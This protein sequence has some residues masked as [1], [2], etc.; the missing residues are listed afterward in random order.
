MEMWQLY[1]LAVL[2]GIK[3]VAQAACFL[4]EHL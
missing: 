4:E 2:P 3:G 1:L